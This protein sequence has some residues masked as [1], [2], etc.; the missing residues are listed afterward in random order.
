MRQIGT[1][2]PMPGSQDSP[3][4]SAAAWPPMTLDGPLPKISNPLTDIEIPKA[5]WSAWVPTAESRQLRRALMPAE[6]SALEARRA[7]L[8]PALEPFAGRTETNRV[9]LALVDMFGA[10]RSMRQTGADALAILEASR[11]SLTQF[12]CWAI[13][14]ACRSIQQNGVWRDGKFDRQWPPSDPEIID[15]V[16]KEVRLYSDQHRNVVALLAATVEER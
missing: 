14:K 12:P 10:F 4:A 5:V 13:E 6:R 1:T 2:L 11:R 9:D 8:A 3:R 15:A 7:E 16:R